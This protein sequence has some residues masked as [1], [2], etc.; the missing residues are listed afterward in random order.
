LVDGHGWVPVEFSSISSG[1]PLS[2][3][4]VDPTNTLATPFLYYT[5]GCDGGTVTFELDAKMESVY[6]TTGDG[7]VDGK[8]G[9]NA[10][11]LYEVGSEPGLDLFGT[12][13][14]N[15]YL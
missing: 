15:F 14:T 13:S 9:G 1:S 4:P 10:T 5:Y 3:L 7:D 11:D 12:P 6:Y 8:D 2:A